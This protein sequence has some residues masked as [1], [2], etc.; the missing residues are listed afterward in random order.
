MGRS[1]KFAIKGKPRVST[2]RYRFELLR[3]A[4][5]SYGKR[6]RNKGDNVGMYFYN[7]LLCQRREGL[8]SGLPAI[9]RS[10]R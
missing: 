9:C 3:T 8:T 6:W 4:A 1:M 7:I 2:Y 10:L 5:A